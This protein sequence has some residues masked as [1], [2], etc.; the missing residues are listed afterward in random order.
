ML[1]D[2]LA[3]TDLF[4]GVSKEYIDSLVK[5]CN[6]V[7]LKKGE[8]LFH[9]WDT[10]QGM[11]IITEGEIDIIIEDTDDGKDHK[12]ASFK[13]NAFFGEV[14]MLKPQ[15]RTAAVQAAKDCKLLYLDIEQF[16]EQIEANNPNALRISHNIALTLIE[17]LKSLNKMLANMPK[18]GS[19]KREM[20]AYKEK[21]MSEVLF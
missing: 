4:T 3:K 12:V 11:Y 13:E 10:G 9:Q 1:L 21:M 19:N 14:C 2:N 8:F 15:N 16:Q 7:D 5:V 18:A 6:E 17:R 20:L